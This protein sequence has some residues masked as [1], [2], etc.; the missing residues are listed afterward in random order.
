M[1]QLSELAVHREIYRKCQ[2]QLWSK[3]LES[4]TEIYLEYG[5]RNMQNLEENKERE[6]FLY[7]VLEEAEKKEYGRIKNVRVFYKILFSSISI[8]VLI[9]LMSTFFTYHKASEIILKKTVRQSQETIKQMSDNYQNFLQ[10]IYD[11]INY[12][13]YSETTQEELRYGKKDIS[14]E[15]YFSRERELKRQMVRLFNSFSV[16]DMEIYANNGKGYYFSVKKEV[17][18]PE[19]DQI[20]QMLQTASDNMGRIVCFNDL[21]NTGHIQIVK[22]VRD[23]LRMCPIGTIR[24][25]INTEAL[26]QIQKNIDFASEGKVLI[27]DEKN[28]IVQGQESVLS[29]KAETLFTQTDG[30]FKYE[31][32]GKKYQVVYHVADGTNWKVIGT[33]PLQEISADVMLIQKQMIKILIIGIL[34]SIAF[35]MGLSWMFVRPIYHTV[36]AMNCFSEGD[37]T[38][39]LEAN[40][41]DEFGEMNR[42]FN[43]TIQKIEELMHEVTNSKLLNKEMEFKA[44]QAQINPH[45][46]YNALD[47]VNWMAMKEGNLEICDMVSAIADLMRI[48]IGNRQNV[49]TVQ[50]E[51]KYVKDYLYIQETRYRDRFEVIFDI[52]DQILQQKIPKLT[53]Q[54]LVENAIVHS[55]EVSR[56]K[57]V[58]MISG[59]VEEDR[60]IIEIKDNGVGMKPETLAHLFETPDGATKDISVAHTGLGVYAVQQRLQYFYGEDYGLTA[61]SE[62]GKGTCIK[63]CIPYTKG[64]EKLWN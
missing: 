48:S 23:N 38:V 46:L 58:L 40:R 33:I 34:L 53:L 18:K 49:F 7:M 4:I 64:E 27:L 20:A 57:T 37:F 45:F 32:D 52:D 36:S 47:T 2:N 55:V 16:D 54:P 5:I 41:K 9:T 31:I 17:E 26:T 63:I 15:G 8:T 61:E 19:K 60:V 42:V 25:S 10:G 12:I 56:G 13:A 44:L 59:Y 6:E 51:L 50:R 28:E 39:R 43:E 35:S 21:K 62:Y 3:T 29:K 11:K 24:L 1:I 30:E 14:E 22:E